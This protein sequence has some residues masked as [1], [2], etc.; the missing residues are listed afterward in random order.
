VSAASLQ[1]AAMPTKLKR[2]S[3]AGVR[4]P[5]SDVSGVP[6]NRPNDF[7]DLGI[8]KRLQSA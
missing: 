4:A 8:I 1:A 7:A 2:P 3:A 6:R 5:P